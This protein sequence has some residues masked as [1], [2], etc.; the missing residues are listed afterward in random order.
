[1]NKKI[2]TIMSAFALIL[3]MSPVNAD[4][5]KAAVIDNTETVAPANIVITDTYNELYLVSSRTVSCFGRTK[6]PSNYIANVVVELQ[7]KNGGWTTIK[8]WNAS[9]TSSASVDEDYSVAGGYYYRLKLTHR[10]YNANGVVE[11]ITKYSNEVYVA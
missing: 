9:N 7:Q 1:M 5:T 4:I 6:T 3:N 11:T 10:A 2:I 8:T